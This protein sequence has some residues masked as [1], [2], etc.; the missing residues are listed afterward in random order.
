MLVGCVTTRYVH[1]TVAGASPQVVAA[2]SLLPLRAPGDFDHTRRADLD[3]GCARSNAPS[4]GYRVI[5]DEAHRAAWRAGCQPGV[6]RF[7]RT[8]PDIFCCPMLPP[9]SADPGFSAVTPPPSNDDDETETPSSGPPATTEFGQNGVRVG[10]RGDVDRYCREIGAPP[11]AW[12]VEGAAQHA[13]AQRLGCR[14]G[15]NSFHNRDPDIYCCAGTI[16]QSALRLSAGAATGQPAGGTSSFQRSRRSDLDANCRSIGAPPLGWMVIG[17]ANHAAAQGAGCRTGLNMFRR[18]DP[19]IY[20]C[21][22]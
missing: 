8:D 18:P 9:S 11:F 13:N 14:E 1:I 7:G 3:E 15:L 12:I 6:N 16:A 20:C 2:Q 21:P 10:R 17:D 22:N 4:F 5:G 19:D